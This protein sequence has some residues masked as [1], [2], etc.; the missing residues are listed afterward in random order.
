MS[1]MVCHDFDMT[2]VPLTILIAV[3]RG[4]SRLVLGRQKPTGDDET[5]DG[6]EFDIAPGDV[7]VI[8]AGVSH[9][10]ITSKDGYRYIG[11]YP[12]VSLIY[13]RHLLQKLITARL[14][15]NGV[16][17]SVRAKNL[18]KHWKRKSLV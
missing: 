17:I 6:V 1:V 5:T 12:K 9:R 2:C 16:T 14:L 13:T 3:I 8:P 10:S 11:V 15:P 4:E 18:L 7:I